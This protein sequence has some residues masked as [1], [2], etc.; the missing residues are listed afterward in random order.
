MTTS[1]RLRRST[2]SMVVVFAVS[3]TVH[4]VRPQVFEPLVPRA[5]PARRSLVY[6][7]G[8]AELICAGGLLTRRRWAPGAATVLLLVLWPGNWKMAIDVQRDPRARPVLKAAVWLRLPLQLA[9][10]RA[11]RSRAPA[12][13]SSVD[14]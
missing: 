3:G 13:Q 10:I 9:M 12:A 11:V 5:L 6:A 2:V 14:A 7:S 8:I 4:L 1:G